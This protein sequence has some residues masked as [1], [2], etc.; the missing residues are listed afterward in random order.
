[1]KSIRGRLTGWFLGSLGVLWL[2]AGAGVFFSYRAGLVAG[3]EAELQTMCRQVRSAGSMGG[4]GRGPG[5]GGPRATLEADAMEALGPDVWWQVWRPNGD[6]IGRSE[7]LPSDLP[8]QDDGRAR[9]V[10]LENG[11]RVMSVGHSYGPG[12]GGQGPGRFNRGGPGGGMEVSVARPLDALHDKLFRMLALLLGSGVV[13]GALA[14]WWV[15]FV[16]RDGLSPLQRIAD[17]IGGIDGASLDGRFR[18]DQ[19]PTELQPIV[20]RLNRLMER[21]QASFTRERRFSADLAHEIRTPLSEAKAIAETAVAWPDEGGPAAWRDVVASAERMEAVVHAMLQLARIESESPG[22]ADETFPLAP[23]VDELW[24]NHAAVAETRNVRLRSELG[25]DA[26]ARGDRAW[27]VHLLGNLLGNA[28]E[29]ADPDSEVV[30]SLRND[31]ARRVLTV[32]NRASGL[33]TGD[34]GHLFER[35]WRADGARSESAHCGLGLSLAT[36]C[37]DA[38]GQR[39]EASLDADHVLEMRVVGE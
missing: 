16:V 26:A 11:T 38:L 27:W 32:A 1:M 8:R 28:A 22:A 37:A 4:G 36:A 18:D 15:R 35:F 39:L 24:T 7:N 14:W 30:V 17:D 3:M 20:D 21:L 33:R 34:V 10:T 25:S 9:I 23:L 29:Y 2:A 13:L 19:L 5:R 31:G 6:E 12:R